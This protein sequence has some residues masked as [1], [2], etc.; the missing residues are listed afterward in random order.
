MKKPPSGKARRLRCEGAAVMLAHPLDPPGTF[1]WSCGAPLVKAL[2]T[3]ISTS[4]SG[5]CFGA[6]HE[7]QRGVMAKKKPR[8]AKGWCQ[9]GKDMPW[10]VFLAVP[11]TGHHPSGFNISRE[12]STMKKPPSCGPAARCGGCQSPLSRASHAAACRGR[13]KDRQGPLF[14]DNSGH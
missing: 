8:G 9:R 13:G 10:V 6:R 1:S 12:I 7:M 2:T 5:H 4:V 11:I 3:W 14:S